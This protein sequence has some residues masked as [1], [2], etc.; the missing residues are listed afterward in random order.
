MMPLFAAALAA[1][2]T[3]G[4][5]RRGSLVSLGTVLPKAAWV[6]PAVLV[7]QVALIRATEHGMPWWILPLHVAL[8]LA[9]GAAAMLDRHLPGMRVIAV[10]LALNAIV[11]A[12]NGGLMPQAPETL[13]VMHA[14]QTLRVGQRPP[15][16]KDVVLPRHETRLWWLS[17]VLATPPAFPVQ[18]VLS[19][20]DLVV[21]AGLAWAVQ[22][23]MV[24]DRVRAP[25]ATP[26]ASTPALVK[27]G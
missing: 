11:I 23:L 24:R 5:A 26:A 20:G 17:D 21:A 12:A 1:G 15:A 18:A 27:W 13:H 25:R 8:Y 7:G 10:G 2:L 19:V 9:L 3:V 14:G 22:G 16:T 4:W 6:V